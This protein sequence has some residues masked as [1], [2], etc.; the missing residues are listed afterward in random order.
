LDEA[1]IIQREILHRGFYEPEVWQ[2]ITS[3][4]TTAEVL[5][6]VGANVGAVSLLAAEDARFRA[7]VAFEPVAEL[8]RLLRS[9]A[10]M[11]QVCID[12][13]EVALG[14]VPGRQYLSL[15]PRGN[16]GQGSLHLDRNGPRIQVEVCTADQMLHTVKVPTI[17]KIDIEGA[18]QEFFHGAQSLLASPALKLIVFESE[19]SGEGDGLRGDIAREIGKYGWRAVRIQRANGHRERFENFVAHR[20]WGI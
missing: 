6:D 7:V 8:A 11:S 1:D 12:V 18:E 15:G 14:A 2:I 9:H 17:V 10:R 19:P 13:R 4:A 20:E 16:Q 5:W 3:Q